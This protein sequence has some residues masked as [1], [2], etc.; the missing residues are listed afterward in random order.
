MI[1]TLK[2]DWHVIEVPSPS[3][4]ANLSALIQ[5]SPR[6]LTAVILGREGTEK[7]WPGGKAYHVGSVMSDG[8]VQ[9]ERLTCLQILDSYPSVSSLETIRGK[10]WSAGAVWKKERFYNQ[11]FLNMDGI[12]TYSE[13]TPLSADLE[14]PKTPF[15]INTILFVFIVVIGAETLFKNASKTK[16]PLKLN[17]NQLLRQ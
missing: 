13:I 5:K 15:L 14:K 2:K 11:Y 3:I 17:E 6:A 10:F 7:C 8:A 9:Y 4:M 1:R 16:K 12:T